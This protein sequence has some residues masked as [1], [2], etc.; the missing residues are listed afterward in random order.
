MI[1][2]SSAGLIER[3][4]QLKRRLFNFAAIVSLLLCIGTVGLW[5]RAQ[6]VSDWIQWTSDLQKNVPE[7]YGLRRAVSLAVATTPSRLIVDRWHCLIHSAWYAG[8]HRE[9]V[10]AGEEDWHD[11]H[12]TRWIRRDYVNNTDVSEMWIS[13]PF[14]FLTLMFATVFI[15]TCRPWRVRAKPG[16]CPICNY[17]LRATPDRCPE[18]GV[19]G[20]AAN[21]GGPN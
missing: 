5:V 16:C 12:S 2:R 13:L 19:A 20:E 15:A 1:G 7:D 21:S 6:F 10:K 17:D 11:W 18:C 9:V 4:N 3:V 8:Y 14:W